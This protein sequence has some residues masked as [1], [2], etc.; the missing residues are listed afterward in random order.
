MG[1]ISDK[2]PRGATTLPEDSKSD[3]LAPTHVVVL[4]D[5]VSG[6][7]QVD[8]SIV[9]DIEG[10]MSVLIGALPLGFGYEIVPDLS[11]IAM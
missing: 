3:P 11:V 8:G 7:G 5:W 2:L 6:L 10:L 4:Q 9:A 1:H